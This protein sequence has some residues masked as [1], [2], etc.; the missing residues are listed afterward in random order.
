[1]RHRGRAHAW[2]RSG[3]AEGSSAD[4]LSLARPALARRRHAQQPTR[5]GAAAPGLVRRLLAHVDQRDGVAGHPGQRVGGCSAGVEASWVTWTTCAGQRSSPGRRA[6]ALAQPR[7]AIGRGPAVDRCG[8]PAKG[9]ISGSRGCPQHQKA[10]R[11]T[12]LRHAEQSAPASRSARAAVPSR[13]AGM[14]NC[15]PV[16]HLWHP[17]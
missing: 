15:R 9:W 13:P 5:A 4:V 1:M 14:P 3:R 2:Q 8:K 7:P 10:Y 11:D 17:G 16:I 6:K 12:A